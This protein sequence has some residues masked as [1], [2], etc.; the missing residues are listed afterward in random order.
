MEL[1]PAHVDPRVPSP[2]S[3]QVRRATVSQGFLQKGRPRGSQ[4]VTLQA[5]SKKYF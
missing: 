3:T 4:E 2:A 1:E 5:Q